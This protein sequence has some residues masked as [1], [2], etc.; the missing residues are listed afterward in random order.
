MK[1]ETQLKLKFKV[2][3]YILFSYSID[4]KTDE[5]KQFNIDQN[6]LVTVAGALDR[7]TTPVHRIHILAIDKGNK[8]C[9]TCIIRIKIFLIILTFVSNL[10]KLKLL[11][12]AAIYLY[13]IYFSNE[14]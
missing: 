3:F 11:L 6:G 2:Y 12:M 8:F 13:S 1:I 9:T 10:M 4:R 5:H 7:E 14:Y